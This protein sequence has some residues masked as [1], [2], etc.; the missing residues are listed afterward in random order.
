MGMR[1]TVV[2][3]QKNKD[4]MRKLTDNSQWKLPDTNQIQQVR[5]TT[6]NLLSV[7]N[8]EDPIT[9]PQQLVPRQPKMDIQE[10]DL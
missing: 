1:E 9:L 10:H 7:V 5:D 2:C 4:C 3:V 6:V 8:D